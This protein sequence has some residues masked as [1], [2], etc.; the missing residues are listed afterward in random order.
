M[1]SF[2]K[3][4]FL[5]LFACWLMLGQT[6]LAWKSATCIYTGSVT[7]GWGKHVACCQKS[8]PVKQNHVSRASCCTYEQFQVKLSAEQSLKLAQ[9]AFIGVEPAIPFR[10]YLDKQFRSERLLLPIAFISSS[11]PSVKR[12]L[13]Q[14]Y[15]I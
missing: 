11:P 4:F 10:I 1:P 8:V 6:G 9:F 2:I 14:V 15:L 5:V 7:Y 3:R 13:I 12:A